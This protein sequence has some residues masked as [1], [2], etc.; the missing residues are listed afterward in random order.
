MPK[1]LLQSGVFFSCPAAPNALSTP[2]II[3]GKAFSL[4][5]KFVN[6]SRMNC[7]KFYSLK[8]RLVERKCEVFCPN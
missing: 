1:F 8:P 5:V 6:S 7:V 2:K 4:P 3:K